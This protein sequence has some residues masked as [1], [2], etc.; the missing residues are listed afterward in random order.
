MA[1]PDVVEQSS[2]DGM[3]PTLC[4]SWYNLYAHIINLR[5]IT[6]G[7]WAQRLSLERP[8]IQQSF[9]EYLGFTSSAS[10]K[11]TSGADEQ[12]GVGLYVTDDR[13]TAEIFAR[14]NQRRNPGTEPSVCAIFAR[15]SDDWRNGIT[16]VFIPNELVG[17][18][19]DKTEKAK[20]EK[21]RVTYLKKEATGVPTKSIVRISRIDK[22][23][24]DF[25][26]QNQLLLPNSVT[27]RFSALCAPPDHPITSTRVP[28]NRLNYLSTDLQTAWKVKGTEHM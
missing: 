3:G 5:Q 18:A 9:S 25:T 4:V 16:K 24:K 23:R 12:S 13:E 2:L 11:L 17:D 6:A 7:F 14:M 20:W 10:A 19:E 26:N 1:L 28:H 8:P 22:Y 15:S 27:S 21:N